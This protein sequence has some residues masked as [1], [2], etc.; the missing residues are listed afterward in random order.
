MNDEMLLI[1]DDRV[2]KCFCEEKHEGGVNSFA[3]TVVTD[4]QHYLNQ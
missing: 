4:E 2:Q 1:Y 3:E